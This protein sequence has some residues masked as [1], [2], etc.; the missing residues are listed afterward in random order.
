MYI[1]TNEE[2]RKI[3]EVAH[4][5]RNAA[6]RAFFMSFFTRKPRDVTGVAAQPA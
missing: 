2:T 3:M 6:V 1:A 5:E 4:A